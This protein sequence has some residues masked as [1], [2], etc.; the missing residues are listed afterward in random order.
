MDTEERVTVL[1]ALHQASTRLTQ[2]GI[3]HPE[4]NAER[5]LC[6]IL[7][8]R[9][10]HLYLNPDRLL[11]C[12][13]EASLQEALEQ[14]LHNRPLQYITESTQFLFFNLCVNEKVFIP[15]PETEI[16]VE[17]AI[18]RIGKTFSS[19]QPHVLVD[20]CTGS[21]N[22]ALALAQAF[23]Q[24]R[25]YAT[26]ISEQALVIARE[27]AK[28]NHCTDS[29]T[30]LQGD[31]FEPLVALD[32]REGVTAIICN[33]PYIVR[34]EIDTLSPEVRNYEPRL[35]L[36]GGHDG[37]E[38]V[39]RVVREATSVLKIKGLLALEVGLGQAEVVRDLLNN[40]KSYGEIEIVKD[41]SGI[42]RVVMAA[43]EGTRVGA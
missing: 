34:S 5:L 1:E 39:R 16:L 42:D 21:G 11:R 33:P 40:E 20:L 29:I 23:P 17:E 7:S 27:N 37:L 15:R 36:D 10:T 28:A 22:I 35:A 43:C 38:I 30:F 32:M 6:F 14:R 31:L 25:V 26:D 13:E 18:R 41:L 24:S 8:C 19:E 12:E 9:R 4:L 2:H 3:E